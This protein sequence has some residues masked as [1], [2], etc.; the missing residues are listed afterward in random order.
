M[1][2]SPRASGLGA[3]LCWRAGWQE[4]AAGEALDLLHRDPQHIRENAEGDAI[5]LFLKISKTLC[6]FQL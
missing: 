3:L 1:R 2:S 4:G 5:S 6:F